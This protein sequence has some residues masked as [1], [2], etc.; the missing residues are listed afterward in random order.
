MIKIFGST[1]KVFNTN[2]DKVIQPLKAKVYQADNGNFYLDLESGLENVDVLVEGNIIIAPT[3][4]GEQAFRISNPVKT[5][6]KITVRAWHVFYDTENYLIVD[7]YVVNKNAGEALNHLNNSTEPSSPFVMSS[8]IGTVDSYRCVRTSLYEAIQTVV[9]RWGG[10]LVRDN[11]NLELR[12]SIGQDNGVTVQYK[13]NL[14]DITC[15]EDWDEVVTKLL[16]VGKDG[17]LLNAVDETANIYVESSVQ[18]AIPYTKS[19]KFDQDDIVEED[20]ETPEAYKQA[21]VNDL[22]RQAT[23]YVEKNC[24]PQISYTLKA[25]LEKITDIGDIVEVVDNRL[26]IHLQTNVI[27]YTYDCLLGKYSDV[28][29]GN[30]QKTLSGLVSNITA[31]VG[32]SVTTTVENA[33]TALSND[34]QQATG[35]IW[36]TLGNSYVIYDGDSIKIIDHLPKETATNVILINNHGISLSRT[37]INGTYV[38]AW[39]IDGT[40][41]MQAVDIIN[42]VADLV[43]GGTLKL[44]GHNNVNAILRLYDDANVKVGE[45][46]KNGLKMFA[47]NGSYVVLNGSE[48]ACYDANNNKICWI[49]NNEF[50]VKKSVTEEEV[51][52]CNKIKIVP[53]STGAIDG[54][55]IISAGG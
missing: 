7:S 2:G 52:V 13:K 33:T 41:N 5:K 46:D 47:V 55:G 17:V 43:K 38:K 11:F 31:S 25:N 21:L 16:P 3:P 51:T 24:L 8:N 23:A 42:L 10:H 35:D 14:K 44:G 48:F 15:T 22:L 39:S 19:V 4:K 6:T 20:F 34:I 9:E 36:A 45:M 27:S 29:F 50:H 26:G 30:F 49:V 1:D 53:I 18:Y 37:G 32:Q 28:S 54:I 40:F 12:S